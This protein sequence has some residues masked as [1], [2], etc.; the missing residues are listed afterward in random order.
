[1]QFF[2]NFSFKFRDTTLTGV[3]M[4]NLLNS[5]RARIIDEADVQ[6]Y[7]YLAIAHY[8]DSALFL[9]ISKSDNS[10]IN[11]ALDKSQISANAY[12]RI[13]LLLNGNLCSNK[14]LTTQFA[15]QEE[16]EAYGNGIG[17]TGLQLLLPKITMEFIDAYRLMISYEAGNKT[18]EQ[19]KQIFKNVFLEEANIL[20]RRFFCMSQTVLVDELV[21]GIGQQNELVR[22]QSVKVYGI[23]YGVLVLFAAVLYLYA[24]RGSLVQL[25]TSLMSL[26]ILPLSAVTRVGKIRDFIV[27]EVFK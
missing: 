8:T 18:H 20:T 12:Q 7:N 13:Q 23:M 11:Q 3:V 2:S 25:H 10:Y 5:M 27:D 17:K 21:I 24:S 16:C 19:K 9:P 26:T 4:Y 22:E 15:S 1:M 14:T 6:S